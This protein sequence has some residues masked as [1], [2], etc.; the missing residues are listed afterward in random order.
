MFLCFGSL[1]KGDF[2]RPESLLKED[3]INLLPNASTLTGMWEG[4]LHLVYLGPPPEPSME[5]YLNH[6]KTTQTPCNRLHSVYLGP[7]S[8]GIPPKLPQNY[9]DPI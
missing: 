6:L 4:K 3:L 8:H 5:Y 1:E 7:P 2:T 9:P